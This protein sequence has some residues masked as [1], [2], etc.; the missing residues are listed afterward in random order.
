VPVPLAGAAGGAEA[1][2]L[3]DALLEA[4]DD[5]DVESVLL[6]PPVSAWSAL[7]TAAVRAL[8]T[9]FSAVWLAML[10]RPLESV[11]DAPNRLLMTALLSDWV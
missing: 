2:E 1:L 8:L 10:D 5:D 11:V 4:L 3:E 9:R 6:E 7:C